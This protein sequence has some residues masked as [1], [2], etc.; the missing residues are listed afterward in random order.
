MFSTGQSAL[1]LGRIAFELLNSSGERGVLGGIDDKD[2]APLLTVFLLYLASYPS[3]YCR[4]WAWTARKWLAD[5]PMMF[6]IEGRKFRDRWTIIRLPD[7][8][9]SGIIRTMT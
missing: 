2:C 4:C 3:L 1:C 5:H 8:A 6:K 7:A 9:H